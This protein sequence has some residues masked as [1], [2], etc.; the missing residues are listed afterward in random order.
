MA[1]AIVTISGAAELAELLK[2]FPDTIQRRAVNTALSKAGGRLR[3]YFRRAAPKREGKLRA[4]IGVG[5]S[6]KKG[7]VFVG[8]R[9][10]LYYKTLEY[11]RG[12]GPPLHP[13]FEAEWNNRKVE[14]TKII[15]DEV[16]K[17]LANEA[18]KNYVRGQAR[19][20]G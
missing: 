17:I 4:S 11:G 8:L 10:N 7:Q 18:G 6:K 3:T 2:T 20:N 12:G 13:F 16:M 1:D 9:K 5:R 15:I 14:I 19:R